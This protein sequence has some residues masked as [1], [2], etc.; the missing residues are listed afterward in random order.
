[1][2]ISRDLPVAEVLAQ[3]LE[4]APNPVLIAALR[5]QIALRFSKNCACPAYGTKIALS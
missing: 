4:T 1:M 2:F 5:D 3:G